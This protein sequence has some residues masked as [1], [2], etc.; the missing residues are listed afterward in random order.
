MSTQQQNQQSAAQPAAK[1]ATRPNEHGSIVVQAHMKIF[2]PKSKKVY[3]EG[4]A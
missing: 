3:V 1:P 2:D 4:R